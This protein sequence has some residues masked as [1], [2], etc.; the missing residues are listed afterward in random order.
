MTN[1][2]ELCGGINGPSGQVR[3]DDDDVEA[4]GPMYGDTWVRLKNG[5]YYVLKGTVEFRL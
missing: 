2:H 5:Q 1:T 4:F 3:F